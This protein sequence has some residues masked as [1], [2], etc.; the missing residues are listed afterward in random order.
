MTHNIGKSSSV[1]LCFQCTSNDLIFFELCIKYAHRWK[2]TDSF[3]RQAFIHCL[4]CAWHSSQAVGNWGTG[5][6]PVLGEITECT[7][8]GRPHHRNRAP[9]A[10]DRMER[11]VSSSTK[12]EHPVHREEE[13]RLPRDEK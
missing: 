5:C 7:G 4:L 6:G 13:G 2:N 10:N 12:D 11:D 8:E 1:S 9:R 3:P